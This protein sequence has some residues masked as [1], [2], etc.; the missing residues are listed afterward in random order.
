M[1]T[2]P[3]NHLRNST[4]VVM[5]G[6]GGHARALIS[7]LQFINRPIA[8]LL[9]D[10]PNK[11]G[12]TIAKIPITA[13]FSSVDNHSPDQIELVN[14]I[15]ST[16]RP[17]TR[18]AIYERMTS[19][20]YHFATLVHPAATIAPD[21]VIEPGAQVMAGAII[22]VGAALKA[23][24]LINTGAIIDHDTIIGE[25]THIA[26]GA[27]ICGGVTVGPSCHIGAGVTVIQCT[28]LSSG[29]VVGAGATVI[30]HIA[31]NQLVT[32][33]PAKPHLGMTYDRHTE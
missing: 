14:A 33:V 27:T 32:G 30:T 21:V 11:H 31:A 28:T 19:Q 1:P 3:N 18:Q 8:A 29:V 6:T 17:T 23:N 12:S 4:P 15:G 22:Q 7:L 13:G 9:D 16:H 5:L 20:G 2:T 26:P 24:C 25:H 10:D